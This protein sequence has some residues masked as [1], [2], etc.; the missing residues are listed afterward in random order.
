MED[1][2]TAECRRDLEDL[3]AREDALIR[4]LDFFR[5]RKPAE[6]P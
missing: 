4:D 6:K 3:L 2:A 5:L 1:P